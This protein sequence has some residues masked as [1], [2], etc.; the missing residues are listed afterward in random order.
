MSVPH[1]L[2]NVAKYEVHDRATLA[3]STIYSKSIF[4]ASIKAI[5]S[6]SS[7]LRYT[8]EP[9]DLPQKNKN[10]NEPPATGRSTENSV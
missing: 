5:K 1:L 4:P 9:P 7:T 8:N 6:P 2:H 3:P 10:K